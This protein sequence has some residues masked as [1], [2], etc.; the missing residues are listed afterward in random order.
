MVKL[1]ISHNGRGNGLVQATHCDVMICWVLGD[2][3]SVNVGKFLPSMV[4]KAAACTQRDLYYTIRASRKLFKH[5]VKL[6]RNKHH[7]FNT[8]RSSV[9][10]E[11]EHFSR[12]ITIKCYIRILT[13]GVILSEE[14][15]T[16][17]L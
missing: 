17:I 7:L 4:E 14:P 11:S 8:S 5:L 12:I 13:L 2:G 10:E 16:P 15:R 1:S 9:H 3:W 6:N